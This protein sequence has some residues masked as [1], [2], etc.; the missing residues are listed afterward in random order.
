MDF[1]AF[2]MV[3]RRTTLHLFCLL[4][5]LGA[6]AARAETS[7]D[8]GGAPDAVCIGLQDIRSDQT[9][10]ELSAAAKGCVDAG[11]GLRAF[12]LYAVA[13]MRVHFDAARFEDKRAVLIARKMQARWAGEL[14]TTERQM[15]GKAM[16]LSVTNR[17]L[18]FAFCA[19]LRAMKL[20]T[21]EPVYMARQFPDA[22][23]DGTGVLL[24]KDFNPELAWA[25]EV[26]AM[27]CAPEW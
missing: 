16:A 14:S 6:E 15:V 9:P 7:P 20:P 22:S 17:P 26:E 2:S 4:A 1:H 12:L 24:K 13:S 11:D 23:P 27:G 8:Q 3:A 18:H 19:Q 21:Y 10:V 25:R 5:A